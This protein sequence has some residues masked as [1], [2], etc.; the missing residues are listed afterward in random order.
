MEK[1][2]IVV[3]WDFTD[4][5]LNAYKHALKIAKHLDN[6]ITLLHVIKTIKTIDNVHAK[7]NSEAENLSNEFNIETFPLLLEGNLYHVISDYVSDNNVN[8]VIMGTHGIKGMQKLMGSAA[9]KVI[10]GSTVPFIVIQDAPLKANIFKDIV[11]PI[12]YRSVSK[13]KVSWALFLGKHFDVKINIIYPTIKDK[14]LANKT[15]IN[16]KFTENIF[17]KYN[18]DYVIKKIP[19]HNSAEETIKF[20]KEINADL[21]LIMTT[22]DIGLTDYMLGA[23]EQYIIANPEKI[24]VMVV[25]PRT[26]LSRYSG[27]SATGG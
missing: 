19:G 20:S 27:F 7:L 5:A 15:A 23:Q 2:T 12:D 8:M 16:I 3:P 1:D 26:D 6:T 10:V 21:I 18:I 9:L 11:F 13:Q 4:V 14:S 17:N 24:P 25:N 22:K